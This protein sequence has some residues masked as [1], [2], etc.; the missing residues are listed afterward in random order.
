METCSFAIGE[1][2][3]PEPFRACARRH[4]GERR[5]LALRRALRSHSQGLR[6]GQRAGCPGAT[7]SAQRRDAP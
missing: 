6:E 1:V 4:V 7:A 2:H 3:L 5:P